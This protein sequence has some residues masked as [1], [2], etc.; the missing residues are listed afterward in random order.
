MS[1]TVR[2]RSTSPAATGRAITGPPL[3]VGAVAVLMAVG[4]LLAAWTLLRPAPGDE[5]A[6]ATRVSTPFGSMTVTRALLTFVPDTQ[7]PPTHAQH[8]GANG[9]RQLQ[10]YL[11][12]E[13]R[14]QDPL[15][16]APG[17]FRALDSEND[18]TGQRSDGST[19]GQGVLPPGASVDGQVW[20]DLEPGASVPRWVRYSMPD[21]SDVRVALEQVSSAAPRVHPGH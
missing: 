21:G 15:R 4:V 12:L 8:V 11:E 3:L 7:G 14:S 10:V 5:A 13:N 17:Q 2:R 1:S 18:R 9:I 6:G 20:F 16:Y 19:L